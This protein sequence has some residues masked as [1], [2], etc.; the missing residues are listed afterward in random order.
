MS[1]TAE[2]LRDRA[3][4]CRNLAK[5]A[6]TETDRTMLEDIAAELDAEAKRVEREKSTYQDNDPA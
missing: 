3:L 2:R 6:R 1:F 5:G 4:D